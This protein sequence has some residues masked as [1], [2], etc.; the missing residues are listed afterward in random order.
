M[1]FRL[2]GGDPGTLRRIMGEITTESSLNIEV[3]EWEPPLV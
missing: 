3:R 1:V 2:G